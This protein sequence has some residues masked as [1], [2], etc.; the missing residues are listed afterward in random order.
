LIKKEVNITHQDIDHES[1]QV[2][3]QALHYAG[4]RTLE[5]AVASG[6]HIMAP[7]PVFTTWVSLTGSSIFNG[8]NNPPRQFDLRS[9]LL[10]IANLLQSASI[11]LIIVYTE[12]NMNPDA[13]EMLISDFEH[14]NILVINTEEL[15]TLNK[16]SDFL[17]KQTQE[18][19]TL[20]KLSNDK[21]KK[22][23]YLMDQLRFYIIQ[24]K[25]LFIEQSIRI[26][27]EQNKLSIAYS[28]EQ[29]QKGSLSYTDADNILFKPPMYQLAPPFIVIGIIM[30]SVFLNYL[31][32]I[33][34][35]HKISNILDIETA[36]LL[37]NES[38]HGSPLTV[39]IDKT[40]LKKKYY[41]LAHALSSNT[42][43]MKLSLINTTQRFL[44]HTDIGYLRTDHNKVT[45]TAP[46]P[47]E[48]KLA[49][50]QQHAWMY[51][52]RTESWR[53]KK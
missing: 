16:T 4:Y 35:P 10:D 26:A 53:Q 42:L 46:S 21:H 5:E 39:T 30:E 7:G 14:R 52:A 51:Y 28:L 44:L 9:N 50:I 47:Q 36:A 15:Y 40:E 12:L 45:D 18:F 29:T 37:A 24:D 43:D 33:L 49:I 48:K 41:H 34:P 22:L 19:H 6:L 13:K 3:L 32:T 23:F 20:D 17:K 38:P 1:Y 31:K 25:K 2:M 11:P 27:R 8:N